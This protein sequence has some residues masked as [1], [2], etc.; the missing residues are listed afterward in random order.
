[1]FTRNRGSKRLRHRHSNGRFGVATVE[2]T[3]GMT[4][5][6]ACRRF[7]EAFKMTEERFPMK[8]RVKHCPHCGAEQP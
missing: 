1:M 6:A 3:F 4:V 5:C 7:F 2:N 8:V